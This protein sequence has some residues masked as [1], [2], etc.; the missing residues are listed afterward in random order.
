MQRQR[1]AD[2]NY[3]QLSRNSGASGR[4]GSSATAG[5]QP[6]RNSYPQ[7]NG[8][9]G[10]QK[11]PFVYPDVRPPSMV[12][13]TSAPSVVPVPA[14]CATSPTPTLGNGG[15][16]VPP[17]PAGNGAPWTPP[18]P[19]PPQLLPP[20]PLVAPMGFV[21]P[22]AGQHYPGQAHAPGAAYPQSAPI[23][24]GGY[25]AD[26]YPA[27]RPLMPA[28]YDGAQQLPGTP[29]LQAVYPPQTYPP[30][31]YPPQPYHTQT[32]PK[33]LLSSPPHSAAPAAAGAGVRLE[34]QYLQSQER[35]C[36]RT[37]FSTQFHCLKPVE[38]VDRT[39]VAAKDRR[40]GNL[41][42][43][44]KVSEDWIA[45]NV[46]LVLENRPGYRCILYV[47]D[48]TLLYDNGL[49]SERLLTKG[50]VH[51]FTSARPVAIYA[52]NPSKTHRAHVLRMW[53]ETAEDH[54]PGATAAAAAAAAAALGRSHRPPHQHQH[55]HQ[56]QQP[57]AVHADFCV[58]VRHVA[59][60]DKQNCLL[61]L[62][63]PSDYQPSFGMTAQI[64]G[65]VARA[66]GAVPK[67]SLAD[68][69]RTAGSPA[70][71]SYHMSQSMLFTRPDYFT[72]VPFDTESE[73]GED[74]WGATDPQLTSRV[75]VDPLRVREDVF[76]TLC[77]L[78][79]GER[80]VYEPYDVHDKDRA[81]QRQLASPAR[82]AFRR[83]W[84]QTLLA[85]LSPD[86]AA[87]A[88]AGRL[89]INGDAAGR[90]RPGDSAYVRR[91]GLH[92]TLTIEN[93]GRAPIDFVV[94]ETPY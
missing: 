79:P 33:L 31:P 82:G 20:P 35:V 29:P 71:S 88:N 56:H 87:V 21:D 48:G 18:D 7:S 23:A 76:V 45:P 2:D 40:R 78:E 52:R 63:Q 50:T 89:A 83:V 38:L 67:D 32:G 77:Q 53:I 25:A 91:L 59:D 57:S 4:S 16:W 94:A 75:C 42:P 9:G 72:P 44:Y 61:T 93:I 69:R 65:P 86:A 41:Y 90:M 30:Q 47:V 6:Y 11:R 58:V 1:L 64:Y 74:E 46:G 37:T 28:L 54:A 43:L 85:A 73:L 39:A 10:A 26:A 51:M 15:A 81:R 14:Q 62:A 22:R 60:T 5:P 34:I 36:M 49:S 92:D 17:D 55:Q 3:L 66:S 84:I 27:A 70:E 80:T 8:G 19:P 12:R 24:P 13:V 68:V